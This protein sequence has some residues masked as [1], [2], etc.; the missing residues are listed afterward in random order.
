MKP[1]SPGILVVDDEPDMCW[2]LAKTL[3]RAG[4]RVTTVG[5]GAEALQLAADA[6]YA[7]AFV[8]AKLP[9][10]DGLE[11]AAFIRQRRPECAVV[12]VSGYLDQE[13]GA[14]AEGLSRGLLAGFVAKPFDLQEIRQVARQAVER[15]RE[16]T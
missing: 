8:D 3:R 13:D 1:Q 5:K 14:V 11:V 12:L 9:D 4:H 16:Q 2:A 15:T 6:P 7:V 10:M